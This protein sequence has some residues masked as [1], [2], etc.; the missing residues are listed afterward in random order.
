M[1]SFHS[2]DT[3][4]SYAELHQFNTTNQR[5]YTTIS[6]DQLLLHFASLN[7]VLEEMKALPLVD[8][9]LAEVTPTIDLHYR[10]KKRE[11]DDGP[12]I[13]DFDSP[14]RNVLIGFCKI[15]DTIFMNNEVLDK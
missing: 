1:N 11:G 13:H 8:F 14:P 2:I 9:F 4:Y 15:G 3:C 10:R 5:W 6:K 7:A 12:L